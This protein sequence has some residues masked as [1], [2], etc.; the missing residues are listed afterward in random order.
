MI[1]MQNYLIVIGRLITYV[2]KHIIMGLGVIFI[3]KI[4]ELQTNWNH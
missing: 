2:I 4:I 1:N 3:K